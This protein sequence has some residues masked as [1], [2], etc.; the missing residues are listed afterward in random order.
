M[1]GATEQNLALAEQA[2]S[3]AAELAGHAG[4]LDGALSAFRLPGDGA[5]TAPAPAATAS[6]PPDPGPGPAAA[7]SA[8][9]PRPAT[10][11]RTAAATPPAEQ[12]VAEFF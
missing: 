3:I 11:G 4:R 7:P 6:A 8:G 2:Q 9:P 5:Q 10:A 1:K 12:S